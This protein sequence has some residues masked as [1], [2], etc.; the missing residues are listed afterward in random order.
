MVEWCLCAHPAM[1][2]EIES[3]QYGFVWFAVD[4]Y[5]S[6]VRFRSS[7]VWLEIGFNG[8]ACNVSNRSQ[9]INM[10][11]MDGEKTCFTISFKLPFL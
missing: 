9:Q 5:F 10:R 1:R 3:L 6:F 11:K 7:D 2:C 4:F 8:W